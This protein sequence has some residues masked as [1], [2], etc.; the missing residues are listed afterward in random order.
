MRDVALAC[1]RDLKFYPGSW[2]LFQQ[3]HMDTRT[4]GVDRTEKTG[5]A[6]TDDH[7]VVLLHISPFPDYLF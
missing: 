7:N 1:A 4:S 5:R 3:E 6:G 2:V